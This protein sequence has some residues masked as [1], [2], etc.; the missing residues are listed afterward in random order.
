MSIETIDSLIEA[1]KESQLL[2]S[3]QIDDL[4]MNLQAGF[5]EPADLAQDLVHRRWLTFYQAREILRGKA[6]ELV[7]GQYILV[8]RLGAGTMAQVYKARHRR[9]DRMDALKVIR[10][11]YLADAKALARF[12]REARAAARLSHPNIVTIYD[13]ADDGDRHFLAME[14]VG[15]I[16]LTRLINDSGPLSVA[17]ASDYVWQAALGLQHA[18]ER[19]LV[20]RDI[21]PS[22]LL[23]TADCILVKLLD[24]GLALWPQAPDNRGRGKKAEPSV[25]M[26]TPDY[27]A[28][29]QTVDAQEVDIRADIYSLGCTFY[30][31]LTGKTPFP[32]ASL[33]Q[34]LLWHRQTEPPPVE[35][36]QPGVPAELCAVVRRM[37]AKL[38]ED[39]Y[40]T[41]N[42]VAEAVQPFCGEQ[43]VNPAIQELRQA[44]A[45]HLHEA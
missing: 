37:M 12:Q 45:R 10:P 40:Q 13:A 23:L 26:G 39:R 43:E 16:D 11:E 7:L 3:L 42:E 18:F 15:G 1:L 38:P 2:T 17:L 21:K 27:I 36:R 8:D 29:E 34:K 6:R 30:F 25:I 5:D 28:P 33:K 24:M 32:D 14:Y 35:S 44:V 41:P 19:D 4:L 20:H 22:N 31:L 9:L